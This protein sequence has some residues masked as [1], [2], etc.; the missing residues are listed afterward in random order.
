MDLPISDAKQVYSL[1]WNQ[2]ISV[3]SLG[4]NRYTPMLQIKTN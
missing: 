3:Q 4:G 2:N 1:V